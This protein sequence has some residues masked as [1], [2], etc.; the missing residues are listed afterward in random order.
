MINVDL[1]PIEILLRQLNA[2][3]RDVLD[4]PFALDVSR[5][6]L[7]VVSESR[8]LIPILMFFEQVLIVLN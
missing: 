5:N 8:F 2:F 6:L 7:F 4:F 3:F 1:A